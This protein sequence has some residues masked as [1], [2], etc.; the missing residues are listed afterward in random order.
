MGPKVVQRLNHG[1]TLDPA[2]EFF[3]YKTIGGPVG[4]GQTNIL[5]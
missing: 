5:I 4:K 2:I 1:K 3:F